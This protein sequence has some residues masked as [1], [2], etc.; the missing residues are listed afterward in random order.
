MTSAE[1]EPAAIDSHSPSY[2][3]IPDMVPGTPSPG[4]STKKPPLTP[5]SEFSFRATAEV[6]SRCAT[7]PSCV[8][9]TV[10]SKVF[11]SITATWMFSWS[12]GSWM[13]YPVQDA[14]V[15]KPAAV[16]AD[17]AVR[18]SAWVAKR[19]TRTRYPIVPCGVS[20]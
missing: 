10:P 2:A 18:A 12:A 6:V 11:G 1:R 3:P 17:A 19:P 13:S 14:V 5:T 9:S 15:R 16:T 20:A 8:A 7:S 4:D